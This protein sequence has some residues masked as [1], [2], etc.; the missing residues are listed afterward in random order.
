[1]TK[2][3]RLKLLLFTLFL[4][5]LNLAYSHEVINSHNEKDFQVS[6]FQAVNQK[7]WSA[8]NDYSSEIERN[9][10]TENSL[11]YFLQGMLA[12]ERKNN[13]EAINLLNRAIHYQPDFIR[14]KLELITIYLKNKNQNLAKEL[15]NELLSHQKIYRRKLKKDYAIY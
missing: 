3:N 1:M 6:V 7:N 12:F 11:Y 8:V 10:G 5:S 9:I 14:A 2:F 4:N 15:I 13:L